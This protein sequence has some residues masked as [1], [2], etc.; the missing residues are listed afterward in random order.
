MS[1]LLDNRNPTFSTARSDMVLYDLPGE[2]TGKEGRPRIRGERLSL[3][4]IP[5]KKPEDADYFLEYRK[6]ITNLWKGRI[7][8]LVDFQ[9]LGLVL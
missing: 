5:R 8:L 2:R 1:R 3:S 9:L 7:V 6:V 4:D